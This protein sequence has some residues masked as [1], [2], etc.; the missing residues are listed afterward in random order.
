M[1]PFS[2]PVR[3]FKRK[4]NSLINQIDSQGRYHGLWEYY[5]SDDTLWVRLHYIHGKRHGRCE[6]YPKDRTVFYIVKYLHDEPRGIC[7]Y[8]R[9]DGTKIAKVYFAKIK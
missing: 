2:F 5:Y 3:F 4:K 8:Y 6:F 9:L 1:F 7:N